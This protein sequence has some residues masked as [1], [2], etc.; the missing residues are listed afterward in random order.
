MKISIISAVYNNVETIEQ[1]IKSVLSQKY[2]EI[3]YIVVD[4]GSTD[5]TL[6]IIKKYSNKID[7]II[8]EK[9]N[10][11]YEA[12]NK[13]IDLATGDII[14]FLHSDDLYSS[15]NVLSQIAEVFKLNNCDG[16]YSD[17]N[18]V[19]KNNIDK[20]LRYWKSEK[21]S[22]SLLKKGWM[23]AHPTLFLK[24]E[25]YAQYGKFDTDFNI[26]ADYDFMLRVLSNGIKVNYIPKVLYLMRIGGV[27][28]KSLKNIINK[29]KED[30]KALKK[31]NIGGLLTIIRK[32]I[33]K[34]PQFFR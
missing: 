29:T 22:M 31:N 4:G 9:D 12:L 8:S 11:I 5:G 32:N 2:D 3:E 23:P 17:L 30:L 33:S 27:S 20:V 6:E 10:G 28:N 19:K 34:I 25:V 16:I 7:V 14:G 15:K 24:K 18:Y 13:G 1:A 21:F 26:A